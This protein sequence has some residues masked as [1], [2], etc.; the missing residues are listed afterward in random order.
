MTW[1]FD[2]AFLA[3]TQSTT[4]HS[5][6]HQ[7]SNARHELATQ[8]TSISSIYMR[9]CS[10]H[11][12]AHPTPQLKLTSLCALCRLCV[13]TMILIRVIVTTT[14]LY[15]PPFLPSPL[16]L[17][18]VGI[19]VPV[20]LATWF[21]GIIMPEITSSAIITS[22]RISCIHPTCFAEGNNYILVLLCFALTV[23]FIL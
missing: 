21:T 5:K 7:A 11:L 18:V 2:Q 22:A 15:L 6:T 23:S 17:H 10:S 8:A 13:V 12:C 14:Y 3:S 16:R 1:I 4:V 20:S 9:T 19:D